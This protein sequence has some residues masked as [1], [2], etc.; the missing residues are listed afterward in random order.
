VKLKASLMIVS[1]VEGSVWRAL[2]D[3]FGTLV[4]Q[5]ASP[6]FRTVLFCAYNAAFHV[7]DPAG[8]LGRAHAFAYGMWLELSNSGNEYES[9]QHRSS[10]R[11]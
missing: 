8:F 7:K 10:D 5:A 6:L 4:F 9:H 3:D 2:G 11:S 1:L